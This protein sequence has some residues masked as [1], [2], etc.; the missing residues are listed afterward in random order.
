MRMRFITTPST[1]A[2]ILALTT[3][4]PIAAAQ[5]SADD[6]STR[7]AAVLPADVARQVLSV[8]DAARADHLPSDALANR[9]LKFAARGIDPQNIAH[10]ATDQLTRL[11]SARDILRSA[12][13][14]SPDSDEIEAGAEA[15]RQGVQGS[16][17]ARLAQSAPSGRSLAVPLYVIGSLVSRGLPSDQALQRVQTKLAAR[18]SDADIEAS[19]RA[20]VASS[21]NQTNQGRGRAAAAGRVGG[22]HGASS[23]AHGPP[24]GIPGNA[25]SHGRPNTAGHGRPPATGNGRP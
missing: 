14:A 3:I 23:G 25:G 21:Q 11:R 19:G 17:V 8:I 13:P 6:P 18:A 12:R 5:S 9:S 1:A 10:A 4:S 2:S 20:S 16:D 22:Q 15:L 24:A 7:L